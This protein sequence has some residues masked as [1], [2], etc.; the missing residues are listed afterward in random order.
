MTS[1]CSFLLPQNVYRTDFNLPILPCRS[2]FDGYE[3]PEDIQ[4]RRVCMLARSKFLRNLQ[5]LRIYAEMFAVLFRT[6]MSV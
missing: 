2:N 3:L 4:E 6:T 1:S 5:V